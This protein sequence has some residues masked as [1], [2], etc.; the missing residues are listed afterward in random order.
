[1]SARQQAL[2]VLIAR[3]EGISTGAGFQTDVGQRV[4]VMEAPT[5]GPDDPESA[6]ALVIGED[7]PGYQGENVVVRLPV[8]VQ[9]HAP[10]NLEDPWGSV[11]A[12]IADIKKAVETDHDLGGTLVKRGLERAST[13]PLA[14]EEGSQYVGAGVAY[15]LVMR[16]G[17][18]TP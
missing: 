12:I 13:S 4:F 14:R 6:I 2:A 9:A 10:A 15:R 18:G 7:E 3:L 17:W 5:L 16:E 8:Q 1:M 11:E